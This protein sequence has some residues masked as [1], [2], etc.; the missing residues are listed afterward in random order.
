M[1]KKLCYNLIVFSLAVLILPF[2]VQAES[3]KEKKED[4]NY[5]RIANYHLSW[6]LTDE[7]AEKLAKWDVVVLDMENQ[8]R[9][10]RLIR[11]IRDLNPDIVILAYIT[12]QEID[13]SAIGQSGIAP[14]RNK[15]YSGIKSEWYLKNADGKKLSWWPGTYLMNV[16]ESSPEIDGQNWNDYVARF[17]AEEIIGSGLWDGVFYDNAWG[18]ITSF[19][20]GNIDIDSDGENE[21]KIR[22]NKA[23]VQGMKQIYQKTRELTQEDII[24]VGNNSTLKYDDSLNGMMLENLSGSNW[25]RL[26]RSYNYNTKERRRPRFNLINSN[27]DNEGN[28]NDF[29][30]MRF[31]LASTLME[32][33]Y[34]SFDYGDEDHSQLWW[35]DE[36]DIGLG[37]PLESSQLKQSVD[38]QSS[39]PRRSRKYKRG[40]WKRSFEHGL[41]V[42]NSS[43][44]DRQVE[45]SGQYE[46]IHG[47][48]PVNDGSIRS[49]ITLDSHDGRILLK[50]FKRLKQTVFRN[51][52][53]ARFFNSQ[54]R[55][56]RNG[57]FTFEE[58]FDGG[59]LVGHVDINGNGKQELLSFE[60]GKL[61]VR[62]D[63][64]MLYMREYPYNVNY[65]KRVNIEV[66]DLGNDGIKEIFVFPVENSNKP[67]KVYNRYGTVMK[68]WYPFGS[69]FTG[70]YSL[71]IGDFGENK[72]IVVTPR[73]GKSRFYQFFTNGFQPLEKHTA[74]RRGAGYMTVA[75]GN[76]DGFGRSEVVVSAVVGSNPVVKTFNA[77]G[78]EESRFVAFSTLLG[79]KP[80][81]AVRTSDVN[82]DGKEDIVVTSEGV[83][84]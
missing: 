5:P 34:Y 62:R 80:D 47:T 74:F 14:M 52:N 73:N 48:A 58:K 50:T 42:L 6:T 22:A 79:F 26:M 68:E 3:A 55:R 45:L 46:H 24:I 78:A 77:N 57:F 20:G 54:G 69:D 83:G 4:H 25:S 59:D 40:V 63:D 41:V 18:N 7:K 51:G 11:K 16:T 81:I 29:R 65:K 30:Q 67:I 43:E 17:V 12:P 10:P 8:E 31:G 56:V 64:G 35:Y 82:F 38:K 9:N 76:L 33:G 32:S 71:D 39:I 15:L 53:F 23:W 13:R 28:R 84:F 44:R 49:R 2:V 37:D 66:G 60:R 19:A 1:K 27:T 70:G 21:P 75:A 36:Y 72:K 61:V